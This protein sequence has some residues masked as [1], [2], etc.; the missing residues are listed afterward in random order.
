MDF[1]VKWFREFRKNVHTHDRIII[2][3]KGGKWIIIFSQTRDDGIIR[4]YHIIIRK[5]NINITLSVSV[6]LHEARRHPGNLSSEYHFHIFFYLLPGP[7]DYTFYIFL[8]TFIL[9]QLLG[10][11]FYSGAVSGMI[12]KTRIM[13]RISCLWME[14]F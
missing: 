11:I 6:W 4:K 14:K 9:S 10:I 8:F 12:D 13:Q 2:V 5:Y 3:E 1:M 7:W